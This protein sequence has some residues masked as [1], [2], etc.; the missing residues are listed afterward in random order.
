V[1]KPEDY[2]INWLKIIRPYILHRSVNHNGEEQCECQ[3]ECGKHKG[4]R[5][6]EING[7]PGRAQMTYKRVILTTAHL[8][9]EPMCDDYSHLRAMCQACH[10]IYDL[11]CR[12][13]GKLRGYAA[14]EYA[15]QERVRSDQWTKANR[16]ALHV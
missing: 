4:H 11:R 13:L 3:G 12:Q 7:K 1:F 2:P 16:L 15:E 10:Q 9:H 5:C 8:C 14:L 6:E